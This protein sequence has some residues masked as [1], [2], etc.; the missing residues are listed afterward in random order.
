MIMQDPKLTFSFRC[1]LVTKGKIL[2][3]NSNFLVTSIIMTSREYAVMSEENASTQTD[4]RI[5]SFGENFLS[6]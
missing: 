5:S 4:I 6:D 3:A 1:Q 2:V